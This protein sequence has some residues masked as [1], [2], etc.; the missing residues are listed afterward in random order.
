MTGNELFE[1]ILFYH[2]SDLTLREKYIRLYALLDRLCKQLTADSAADFSNLFSRLHYLCEQREIPSKAIEVFRIHGKQ[3]QQTRLSPRSFPLT[4]EDYLYDLKALCEL[5]SR[6]SS[7]AIP[8]SLLHDLPRQWRPLPTSTYQS[9][10][11]KRMRVVAVRWDQDFI[12]AYDEA[13]P[14]DEPFPVICPEAFESLRTQLFEG[15]QLNLLAVHTDEAGVLSPEIIVFE[16]DYLIDISALAACYTNYGSSPLQYLVN[17]LIPRETSFY[18]LLGNAA[19][20]FLDDCVNE[21][22]ESPATFESSIQKAF[23][24]NVMEYCTCPDIQQDYFTRA[25]MQFN[26]IHRTVAQSFITRECRIDKNRAVLEPSFLCE[27]L[28]LQGRMD[29]LQSDGRNLIELKSGKAE[30]WGGEQRSKESHALQMAL[31]KEVLYYNLDIP[32]EEVHSFLF[33]SVYPKLFLE[34]SSKAQIQRAIDLRNRIVGNELLIKNGHPDKVLSQL[35]PENLNENGDTSKLWVQWQ[36]PKLARQLAPLEAMQGTV[37]AYFNHFLTFIAKEQFLSKTG[38]SQPDSSRGFSDLWNAS[39]ST[40]QAGG[41]ILTDLRII[42]MEDN[43]GIELIALSVPD[44]DEGFLPNFRQGDIVLLYE[45]NADT[46]NATNRQVFRGNIESIND[47]EVCLRLRHKQ[48]NTQV[49][50]SGSLYALE[51]DFMDSSFNNLYQGLYTFLTAPESRRQL[52][53]GLRKPGI[54]CQRTL[55]GHYKNEQIDQIVLQAKQAEDYFLLIGPPGTGKTSVALKSMVEEFCSEPG[56]NILLL[57]YTN[58]AVDEIC[59]MLESIADTPD[60]VRI[61][62]SLSCEQRFHPRLLQNV[63]ASCP[64]RGMIRQ[65]IENIHIFVGT[66]ASVMGKADLFKLKQFQVAIIDEASQILEPQLLGILC[67]HNGTGQCAINKFIL[68]GDHKQLPAVVLQ[69]EKD[70][71]V[72][73]PAL[74][75][76]GLTDRR[77]SFFER[78]YHLQ[79]IHPMEGIVAMLNRQGRMHP[80]ISDFAN[81]H[82]YGGRLGIVPVPHQTAELEFGLCPTAETH[83]LQYFVAHTRTGFMASHT[84]PAADSNKINREEA[85][86]TASLVQSIHALCRTNLLPF[87]AKERIGIIVPFRNQIALIRHELRK[88]DIPEADEITIDT[89]ERYQGSQRDIIIYSTTIS[90]RYQLDILSV[91]VRDGELWID[92]KLNVAITRAKKQFFLTGNYNLL[93]QNDIYR[94]FL[95]TLTPYEGIVP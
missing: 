30:E 80:A 64:N 77:N 11:R 89:V 1:E 21:R 2:C 69:S 22:P 68:V 91:P 7:E 8:G 33:Y 82:F 70:S 49:F 60:Y 25:H 37:A 63:I 55:N 24:A 36:R 39:L 50:S 32:R 93:I 84:P 76:I 43:E 85:H 66:T 53:L 47:H 20:Q 14:S 71:K 18:T 40:K 35:T 9:E 75:A 78:L 48:R 17:K 54:C 51:H 79:Q 6:L 86:I 26:H 45:R 65:A 67:A 94:D 42:R 12:Y 95:S 92:R 5:V 28:G 57:S 87:H 56:Y 4:E 10:E 34:R 58:R 62:S 29:L 3:T 41:N 59:E 72:H 15:A 31:Y 73:D 44:Y 81:R 52:I 88:M 13:F 90:Q 27:S 83:P 46:D 74:H 16:P 61:G 23:R 38:D 19:N